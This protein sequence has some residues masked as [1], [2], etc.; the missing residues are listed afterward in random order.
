MCNLIEPD[1][2][3]QQTIIDKTRRKLKKRY[4]NN[5]STRTNFNDIEA[6]NNHTA[7]ISNQQ[8]P[9]LLRRSPNVQRLN[10]IRPEDELKK[11]DDIEE[12]NASKSN[13]NDSSDDDD[14]RILEPTPKNNN[15]NEVCV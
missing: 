8:P 5:K 7:N 15:E 14:D 3:R 2:Q 10:L 1:K 6:G 9:I 11:F 4:Y 13:R 12:N